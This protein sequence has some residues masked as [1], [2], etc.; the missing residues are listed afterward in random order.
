MRSVCYN[1][2]ESEVFC[3]DLNA[4]V[5]VWETET[6]QAVRKW[7]FEEKWQAF[8]T[9]NGRL[10]SCAHRGDRNQYYPENSAEGFCSA[11]LAGADIVEADIRVT[12][13]GVPVV[14]HDDSLT[15]TT[16]VAALRSA[17]AAWVPHSDLVLDWTAEEI[18][19]LRLIFPDGSPTDC[20]IPTLEELILL[21]KDRCFITL[22]KA[23]AFSF[24]EQ[25]MPII[26]KH[27]AWR[28]VLIPYEYAF[29][30]VS[31]IQQSIKAKCGHYA[32]YFAK[33]VRGSGVMSGESLGCAAAFLREN[34]FARILR[35]GEYL[36]EDGAM[37]LLL[38][39]VIK[40][41]Y[42]LY[43]ESL[44]QGH[45]CEENWQKMAEAGCNILMGNRNYELIDFVR[46]YNEGN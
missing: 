37:Q 45:D 19:R 23:G 31:V 35:G 43:A 25:V 28:T 13:D 36:P 41:K 34:G 33:G 3:L 8:H 2:D 32:P 22:D 14:M 9:P 4:F 26:E 11:I 24:E 12:K 39:G 16:N 40:G 7:D 17:D 29:E 10:M 1:G 38:Q 46:R 18:N 30:R 21:A 27:G 42:R 44:R 5:P 6:R 15:R 20:H